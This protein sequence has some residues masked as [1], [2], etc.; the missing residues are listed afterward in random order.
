MA[1]ISAMYSNQD[2]FVHKHQSISRERIIFRNQ[3]LSVIDAGTHLLAK[4]RRRGAA[5]ASFLSQ[6]RARDFEPVL[7]RGGVLFTTMPVTDLEA[8][9]PGR[10]LRLLWLLV[11]VVP[12]S[13]MFGAKFF[14]PP[15][16]DSQ[17]T[18]PE[19]CR[20]TASDAKRYTQTATENFEATEPV[21]LGGV[22]VISLSST[23]S[24]VRYKITLADDPTRVISVKSY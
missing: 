8:M 2:D 10:R 19:T 16:S 13:F 22:R 1:F 11:L 23:C 20:N 15:E 24:E 5:W 14:S 7:V 4:P 18:A 17:A 21:V 9:F 3:T 12:A 6:L